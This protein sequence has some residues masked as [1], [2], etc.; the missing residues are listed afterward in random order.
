MSTPSHSLSAP[1]TPGRVCGT[2]GLGVYDAIGRYY[3]FGLTARF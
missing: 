2:T 1:G 3:Q